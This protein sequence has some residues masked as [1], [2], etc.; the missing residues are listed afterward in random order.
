[1]TFRG[2]T[3][4]LRALCRD[5]R[6]SFYR[7]RFQ[8][9]VALEGGEAHIAGDAVFEVPVRFRGKGT[10]HIEDGVHLG[11]SATVPNGRPILL[12][13]REHASEIRICSSTTLMQGCELIARTSIVIGRDCRI[14]PRSVIYDSDFHGVDPARRDD[15]GESEA[16]VVGDNVWFGAE[17]M[18]LKGVKIGNDSVVA[19]R[20]L[21][22]DAVPP[23][24]VVGVAPARVLKT[25]SSIE[26]ARGGRKA[27]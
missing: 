26:D 8:L 11:Y 3:Y 25:L 13:P 21:V 24:V 1:M 22:V 15:P 12:E 20:S 5:F 18:V 17:V 6:R 4:R 14:G 7:T 16:V 10:V 19:A 2:L 27:E 9:D 23:R